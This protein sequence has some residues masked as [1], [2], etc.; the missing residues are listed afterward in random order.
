MTVTFA[1]YA[2][3]GFDTASFPETAVRKIIRQIENKASGRSAVSI[4]MA[5]PPKGEFVLA[6]RFGIR[7]EAEFIMH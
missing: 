2:G 3:A 5:V 4:L 1:F 7:R 6:D